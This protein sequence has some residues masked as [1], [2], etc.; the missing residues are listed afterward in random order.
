MASYLDE[1]PK[2]REYVSQLPIEAMVKA[3][4]YKQEKYEKNVTAIQDQMEKIAG[5][6][7]IKDVDKA[8]LQ[9]QLDELGGKLRT[10][11]A[12][13]FSNF[14]L[15]NSVSGMTKQI[16]KDPTVQNAVSSTAFYR[17]QQEAIENARKK[18][19]SDKNN[20]DFFYNNANKWMSDGVAGSKFSDSFVEH[21]DI[22]KKIRENVSAAGID[23]KYVEQMFETDSRGNLLLDKNNHPIPARVMATETLD[24]NAEK[25][26]GIIANVLSE[27]SV[28]QQ[29]E[30]DGWANTRNVPVESIYETFQN[31]F[32]TRDAINNQELLTLQAQIDSNSL[33]TEEKEAVTNRINNIKTLQESNRKKL[34]SLKQLSVSNPEQFKINYY[35]DNYTNNLINGFTTIKSKK[36]FKDSPLTKVLQW[37]EKMD[38]DRNKEAFDR[39]IALASAA[40]DAK[41]LEMEQLKFSADYEF[42]P[43]TGQYKKVDTGDGSKKKNPV[44]TTTTSEINSENS[45][46]PI[47]AQFNYRNVTSDLQ[48]Q[49]QL[50]GFDLIYTYLYKLNNGKTKDGKPFTKEEAQKT[51]NSL[52]KSNGESTY[53]FIM[54]FSGDLKNKSELIGVKLSVQDLEKVDEINKLHNDIT[55]R[56]A[57][58]ED[59]YRQVKKESG[60]DPSQYSTLLKPVKTTDENGNP[61]VISVQDQLDYALIQGSGALVD[62]PEEMTA[63]DR[64]NAKYGLPTNMKSMFIRGGVDMK[65]FSFEDDIYQK[66]GKDPKFRKAQE[67]L[68]DKFKKVN[69]VSDN[70]SS[71]LMGSDD[72]LK[73]A[74]ARLAPLFNAQRLEEVE[75]Q[76]IAAVL[77]EPGGLITY[78]AHRPTRE[79]EPWTG[80]I[81][82]TDKKGV[83]HSVDVDQANLQIITGREFKNY[84]EDGLR[85]R[86]NVS[87]FGST[88]LGA[89]T[90]DL[91]AYQSA[92]IKSGKFTS[93]RNSDYTAFADVVPLSGGK[94]G[95]VIYAKDK[96]MSNFE[97]IEMVPVKTTING[98]PVYFTDYNEID[99]VIPNIT[100]AMI[101]NELTKLKQK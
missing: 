95:V 23:S 85:A 57:V 53:Q 52:A 6:D 17:K 80:T 12:G 63:W 14:Q 45:G 28:Q 25:V 82:V 10:F 29:L 81:Y 88:N 16:A 39:K 76:A 41:R 7:V 11:A 66:I 58:T 92:A 31:D 70:F 1:I 19:R 68:A 3:G 65:L 48:S 20:E 32:N 91:N 74:K 21:T 94:L 2:F 44:N 78:D 35:Q 79:G 60:I 90:T 84:V 27:G 22:M 97:R 75:Q 49:A 15:T 71:T 47:D 9:S 77:A 101:K 69:V 55:S 43:A 87:E 83:K 62:T 46:S 64:L 98:R 24:T 89:F 40:R 30:I 67:L 86:A 100:P 26:K 37:E 8:Y 5:L 56:L 72:E 61:I 4:V 18:G 34:D 36:E 99:G 38:F 13:D 51:V 73:L 54:R 42:D 93:L 59:I 33:S 96:T 50:K